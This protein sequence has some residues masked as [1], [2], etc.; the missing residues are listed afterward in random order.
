M[1]HLFLASIHVPPMTLSDISQSLEEKDGLT[2]CE[3]ESQCVLIVGSFRDD[4]VCVWTLNSNNNTH[5]E[6]PGGG[7]LS[8][9]PGIAA[10]NRNCPQLSLSCAAQSHQHTE[11]RDRLCVPV[12]EESDEE[13][14]VDGSDGV[15]WLTRAP[16]GWLTDRGCL[17]CTVW[18]GWGSTVCNI[19]DGM[20][21]FKP[22]RL[23]LVE[24]QVRTTFGAKTWMESF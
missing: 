3:K 17:L 10:D 13:A 6:H 15:G 20:T 9:W 7:Q 1:L 23:P 4:I 24:G 8:V 14:S 11:C 2:V 18:E 19:A 5:L 16:R 21:V 12:A 22:V